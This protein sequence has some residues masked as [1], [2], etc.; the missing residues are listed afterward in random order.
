M[1]FA[2][3][4]LFVEGI[5]EHLLLSIFANYLGKSLED[6]HVAVIN[7]GGRYF[8]HFLYLFDSLKENTIPK[9]IICLTDRDPESKIKSDGKFKKCY[10]FEYNQDNTKFDYQTNPNADLYPVGS[11]SNITFYSQ[12]IEKGKT[13][14]YEIVICNPS[15]ELLLTD[16]I[17]NLDEIKDLMTLYTTTGKT[18]QDLLNRLGKS[19]ENQRLR[20]SINTCTSWSDEDKKKAIIASRYLNSVGKGENALELSYVLQ[21][22][23][24]KKGTDE[25]K[26]FNVP[27]Y[28]KSAIEE[29][30]Q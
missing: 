16:S 20:D 4:V 13:F 2:Q 24:T 6:N 27:T 1:L 22:N 10:P 18:S 14:E 19:E 8:N 15:L 12:P 23:L 26:E 17:S 11:H 30:C 7:V 25:Y 5:A 29:L 9:K 21:E 28:I 3:K